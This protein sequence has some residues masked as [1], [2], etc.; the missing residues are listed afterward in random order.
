MLKYLQI[1]PATL[2]IQIASILKEISRFLDKFPKSKSKK[3]AG[4]IVIKPCPKR[5]IKLNKSQKF[6]QWLGPDINNLTDPLTQIC[7]LQILFRFAN[8]CTLSS[9]Y[10][11]LHGST[12]IFSRDKAIVFGDDGKNIGK[13]TSALQLGLK[14]KKF[15]ADEFSFY[16]VKNNSI[17]GFKNL[18]I[19]L[20]G[21][22]IEHFNHKY[23]FSSGKE[24]DCLLKMSTFGLKLARDNQ[25]SMIIYPHYQKRGRP[26]VTLLSPKLSFKNL[27]ILTTSHLVKLMHP[28]FDGVSWLQQS[29]TLQHLN[30]YNYCHQL[31]PKIIGFI[32]QIQQRVSSYKIIVNNYQQINEL[33]KEAVLKERKRII[34][35]KSASAVVYTVDKKKIILLKKQNRDWVLPKGHIR[36]GESPHKAALREAKEEAGVEKGKIIKLLYKNF[37][38]FNPPWGFAKHQKEVLIYLVK[39][40]AGK[41][42]ALKYEG[43]EKVKMFS[44]KEALKNAFHKAEKKAIKMA[45][46]YI[47]SS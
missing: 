47:K 7:L 21:N 45:L 24:K 17:L 28:K 38:T 4:S 9:P 46:Q 32:E 13:T 37:Y 16:D 39:S 3:P 11:L 34:K 36:K 18:P 43:F 1:G 6:L 12:A 14:S 31:T 8:F 25:L 30:I 5:K 10:L 23:H 15:I 42:K 22:S 27:E 19:H 20:R 26:K 2:K 44:P 29:N 41:L 35:E 33:I 40:K